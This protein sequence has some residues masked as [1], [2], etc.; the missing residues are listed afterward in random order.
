MS[1]SFDRKILLYFWDKKDNK[2]T[3]KQY[4]SI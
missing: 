2:K 4:K 1:L 3:N